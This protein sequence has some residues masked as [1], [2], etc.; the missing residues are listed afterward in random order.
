MLPFPGAAPVRLRR[1]TERPRLVRG[2]HTASRFIWRSERAEGEGRSGNERINEQRKEQREG[3]GRPLDAFARPSATVQV[4]RS[5]EVQILVLSFTP[6]NR[7]NKYAMPISL[8]VFF[9]HFIKVKCT[10]LR[11]SLA[12][13]TYLA[14]NL[15]RGV[16]SM[17]P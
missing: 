6:N 12:L 7:R 8:K 2:D 1:R 10:L 13:S 17:S 5:N 9:C 15:F 14:F 16:G 11:P 4:R 3:G